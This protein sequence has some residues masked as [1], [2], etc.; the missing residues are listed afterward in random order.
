[1]GWIQ[2]FEYI[3]LCCCVCILFLF[4]SRHALLNSFPLFRLKTTKHYY[5]NQGRLCVCVFFSQLIFKPRKLQ[6][7]RNGIDIKET[8]CMCVFLLRG[9]MMFPRYFL[10]SIYL[11]AKRVN[12]PVPSLYASIHPSSPPPPPSYT[13]SSDLA[14]GCRAKSISVGVEAKPSRYGN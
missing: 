14:G 1:M 2:F 6:S 8:I 9:E 12:R 4:R 3:S 10:R 11:S 7:A 5:P 13:F